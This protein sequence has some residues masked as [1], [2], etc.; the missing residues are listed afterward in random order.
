MRTGIM[1]TAMV[2]AMVLSGLTPEAQARPRPGDRLTLT[3]YRVMVEPEIVEDFQG[4]LITKALHWKL[5]AVYNTRRGHE[6]LVRPK[7]GR[8]DGMAVRDRAVRVDRPWER[9]DYPRE[10]RL[11]A[12]YRKAKRRFEGLS[13]SPDITLL[14]EQP[15]QVVVET[16]QVV[17]ETPPPVHH[18]PPVD[19]PVHHPPV[20][21]PPVQ[22]GPTCDQVLLEMGHHPTHLDECRGA[23]PNC[24]VTLL[25]KKHHPN[26]LDNCKGVEP[27]CA[28]QVLEAGHHP[29]HLDECTPDLSQGCVAALLAAGHHPNHLDKCSRVDDVC[30][31]TLLRQ[32]RHPT[33]LDHCRRR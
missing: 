6:V 21:H 9:A 2:A 29:N 24:A 22:A 33:H 1:M 16:P 3:G 32:G 23:E 15:A 31:E 5:R 26:H 4:R 30:A 20:H 17:V 12:K 7:P 8:R 13:K 27:H 14:G 19:P 10:S 18:H 25:R 11:F 28:V